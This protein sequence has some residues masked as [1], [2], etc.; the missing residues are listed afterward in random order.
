MFRETKEVKTINRRRRRL[1]LRQ[2]KGRRGVNRRRRIDSSSCF[3]IALR[4]LIES[5][6]TT[7]GITAKRDEE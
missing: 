3:P 1:R 4:L 2:S 6:E 7:G 5:L